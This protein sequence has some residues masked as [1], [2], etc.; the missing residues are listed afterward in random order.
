MLLE[1]FKQL[2]FHL[3]AEEVPYAVCGGLGL[4]IHGKPRA[5]ID[6]DLLVPPG[7]VKS[8]TTIASTLNFVAEEEL[9]GMNA[10]HLVIT[11]M[12]RV[13][14]PGE[15][16]VI[17]DVIHATGSLQALSEQREMFH[18]PEGFVW[19]LSREA[20]IEMKLRRNSKQD[21]ADIEALQEPK[22]EG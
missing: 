4:A 18:L 10:G 11:R 22:G 13:F 6:I 8:V 21:Q 15:D 3:N 19:A 20:L 1:I 9:T 5:T 7:V 12:V 2:I 17:L 14:P 16:F